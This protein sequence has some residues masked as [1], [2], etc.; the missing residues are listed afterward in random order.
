M[1]A[2]VFGRESSGISYKQ[3]DLHAYGVGL[4]L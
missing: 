3:K 2:K 1:F 4:I